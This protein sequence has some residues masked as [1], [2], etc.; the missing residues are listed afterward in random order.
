ML[1][2]HLQLVALAQRIG[3]QFSLLIEQPLQVGE[4]RLDRGAGEIGLALQLFGDSDLRC[5][6]CPC[7]IEDGLLGLQLEGRQGFVQKTAD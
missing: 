6:S 3:T 4:S 2:A 7:F 5:I 1:A